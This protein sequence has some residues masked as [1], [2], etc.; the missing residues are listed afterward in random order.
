MRAKSENGTT[1]A[2][3]SQASQPGAQV[4]N[5]CQA[6]GPWEARRGWPHSGASRGSRAHYPTAQAQQ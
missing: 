3:A 6:G 4:D 2:D 1:R 5:R